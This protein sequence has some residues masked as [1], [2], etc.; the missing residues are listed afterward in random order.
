MLLQHQPYSS[1]SHMPLPAQAQSWEGTH[2]PQL[3]RQTPPLLCRAQ[4]LPYIL[5]PHP[6]PASHC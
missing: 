3:P 6:T 2:A 1:N 4:K 5:P